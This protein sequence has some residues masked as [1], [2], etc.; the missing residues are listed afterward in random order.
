MT[1]TFAGLVTGRVLVA[2]AGVT[3]RSV[4]SALVAMGAEVTVTDGNAERLAELADTGATLV[5]GLVEPPEGTSLVVTSPGWKPTSPLLA[6]AVAAGIDVVGEVELAW[7]MSERL[8]DPPT[9]LVVTGTNGKTTT[10]GMLAEILRADGHNA[11]ACGN[12]GLTVIDAIRAGHTVLAVELSSFQ[13]HWQSSMRAHAA[14]VLNLA[15]DHLDWHGSMEEYAKAKGRAYTGAKVV[16]RNVADEWSTALAAEHGGTQ[17]GFGLGVP[18]PGELGLVEDLL[19]DRA[20]VADP[21]AQAEELAELAD[22]NVLGS[23][24]VSNALAAAALA[25]AH[26]VSPDAVRAGL[27]AFQPGAHRAV[28][29]GEF[30]GVSY[31][32]D[33]KATNPHAAAGSLLS[34]ESVVWIAG[35]LLKGA[36]VDQLV[37]TAVGRLRG[38]VLLGAEAEVFAASLARHAP[39]VPVRRVAPGDHEPMIAAVRAAG[40]MARSGD[41]V[42]LA[43]AAASMDMFRDYAHRGD[44]FAAAVAQVGEDDGATGVR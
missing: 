3:G 43:P 12:V 35:G 42:L 41:V 27:R 10:V 28:H 34:F 26:G 6:A 38:V 20:F 15:E 1:G 29:L 11:I 32:N 36:T 39:D 9:W 7:W 30:N 8:P 14:A 44:A 33:S 25:R 5:P 22:L 31:I 2:G 40:A 18:R 17:V 24:N 4:A 23:H 16:V 13:L 19:V 37:E 21:A